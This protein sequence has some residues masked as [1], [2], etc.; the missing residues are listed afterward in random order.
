MAGGSVQATL[1]LWASSLRD[2]K[3]RIRPL[4]TTHQ[5]PWRAGAAVSLRGELRIGSGWRGGWVGLRR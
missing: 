1:E 3:G 2:V 5:I 4:L